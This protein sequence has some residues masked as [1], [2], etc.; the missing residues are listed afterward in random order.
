MGN[1]PKVTK[2][3]RRAPLIR[4]L[5]ELIVEDFLR[6]QTDVTPA[7]P[8]LGLTKREIALGEEHDTKN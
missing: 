4:L 3:A 6:E 1:R 5:A 2:E 7:P 8:C